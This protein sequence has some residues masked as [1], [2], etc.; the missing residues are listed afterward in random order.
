MMWSIRWASSALAA[1][2]ILLS[3]CTV[4]QNFSRNLIASNKAEQNAFNQTLLLN[5]LRSRVRE[6]RAYSRFTAL[7]GSASVTSSVGLSLPFLPGISTGNPATGSPSLSV[8][9]GISD[10]VAPQEDQEFYRGILTPVSKATWALYQDQGWPTDL[11]FHVLVEQISISQADFQKFNKAVAVACTHVAKSDKER[12]W[13]C[14]AWD[15]PRKDT[16]KAKLACSGVPWRGIRAGE[17]IVILSNEPAKP[18]ERFEFEKFV[19]GL[20]AL[21]FGI[22]KRDADAV[23]PPIKA[24]AFQNLAWIE[25][26]KDS[27]L[28]VAP[29]EDDHGKAVDGWYIVR[30]TDPKYVVQLDNYPVLRE[31]QG[32]SFLSI[33]RVDLNLNPHEPSTAHSADRKADLPKITIKTRSPDSALY[34]LGEI[35]RA[36]LPLSSDTPRSDVMYRTDG[37][38]HVLL[39]IHEGEIADSAVT[40]RFAGKIYSV[41]RNGNEHTMQLFELMKQIFA[42]YNR[43]STAPA[44]TAVTVVP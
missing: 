29:K 40:V 17:P 11:L 14:K 10:D 26:L 5:I 32:R 1:S 20:M 39:R 13:Q 43:A 31:S 6:P 19:Y 15:D 28:E 23:G 21:G 4:E 30:S 24:T 25:K 8:T 22:Q 35:A 7:R 3:G 2:L 37:G 12:T 42:L 16:S 38:P 9:P 44:T 18:C 27:G 33:E 34:Y 36:T 41:A